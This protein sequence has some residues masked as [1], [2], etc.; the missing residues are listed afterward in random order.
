MSPRIS[1]PMH[2]SAGGE[3]FRLGMWWVEAAGRN[4]VV[5]PTLSACAGLGPAIR[6]LTTQRRVDAAV[7]ARNGQG[8]HRKAKGRGV[9]K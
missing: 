7:T 5:Q 1:S 4:L 8:F 3:G 2:P 9:G 6:G